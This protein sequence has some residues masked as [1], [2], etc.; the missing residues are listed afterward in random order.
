MVRKNK[1]HWTNDGQSS[2]CG[3]TAVAHLALRVTTDHAKVTCRKGDCNQE[4]P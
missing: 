2:A 1:V 4:N 3:Q